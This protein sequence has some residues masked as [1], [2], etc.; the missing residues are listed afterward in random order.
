MHPITP[1]L[2]QT[3]LALNSGLYYPS[4]AMALALPDICASLAGIPG[5]HGERYRG[6]IEQTRTYLAVHPDWLWRVRCAFLHDATVYLGDRRNMGRI[7]LLEPPTGPV[8]SMTWESEP[9]TF[10]LIRVDVA[11]LVRALLEAGNRWAQAHRDLIA[12]KAANGEL[13]LLQ[14]NDR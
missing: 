1:Y 3:E 13:L 9:G 11:D 8:H 14:P 6:W 4:L 10:G 12:A 7:V 2:E 5:G